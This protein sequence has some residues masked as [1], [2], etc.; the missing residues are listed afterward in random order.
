MYEIIQRYAAWCEQ[1][2]PPEQCWNP[3]FA[4]VMHCSSLTCCCRG[5]QLPLQAVIGQILA[6]PLYIQCMQVDADGCRLWSCCSN[7]VVT[8][9]R[10][11][12]GT[13]VCRAVM[14]SSTAVLK[15]G[16]VR[17][18][19]CCCGCIWR[20]LALFLSMCRW[21]VAEHTVLHA[22]AHVFGAAAKPILSWI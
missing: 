11:A 19:V 2:L 13:Y 14:C 8:A 5:G 1:W 10:K 15:A 16:L 4:T 20:E 6:R 3:A 17:V 18:C 7:I 22:P 9:A 21:L 12:I